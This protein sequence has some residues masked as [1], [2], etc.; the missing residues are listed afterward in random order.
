MKIIIDTKEYELVFA[1]VSREGETKPSVTAVRLNPQYLV[2]TND[3]YMAYAL[4]SKH[5]QYSRFTGRKVALTK[6]ME[7]FTRSE[8]KQVW[9]QYWTAI[10]KGFYN[11]S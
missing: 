10:G 1:H 8:R 11:A 7:Q 4:C 6:L 3:T 2:P 5:D 9:T